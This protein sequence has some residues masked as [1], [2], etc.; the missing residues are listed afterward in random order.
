MKVHRHH[1]DAQ[2]RDVRQELNLHRR[3]VPH[4]ASFQLAAHLVGRFSS[5]AQK[6]IRTEMQLKLQG[7]L[8]DMDEIDRE[9][10]VLRQF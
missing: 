6:A 8:N 9:I 1:L 10:I 4:T 2:K 3:S 7:V 5:V